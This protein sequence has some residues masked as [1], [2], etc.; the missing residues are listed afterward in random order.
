MKVAGCNLRVV[1]LEKTPDLAQQSE[2]IDPGGRQTGEDNS[3]AS[4]ELMVAI[5]YSEWILRLRH[6]RDRLAVDKQP[7]VGDPGPSGSRNQCAKVELLRTG[8]DRQGNRVFGPIRGALELARLHVVELDRGAILIF[9]HPQPREAGNILG[10]EES[11]QLNNTAG[12]RHRDHLGKNGEGVGAVRL[13]LD[14][15][16]APACVNDLVVHDN[17]SGWAATPSC[18]S[19]SGRAGIEA[20]NGIGDGR[21]GRSLRVCGLSEG[22]NC[23]G[24]EKDQEQNALH[25]PIVARLKEHLPSEFRPVTARLAI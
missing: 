15:D 4:I 16:G 21:S 25:N 5:Q 19:A 18:G 9:A 13:G 6:L 7:H 24:C 17:C 23:E 20:Q 10:A 22:W 14:S 11:A 1:I 8:M 2:V 3:R 12:E